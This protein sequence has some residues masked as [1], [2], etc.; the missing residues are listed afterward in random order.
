[1]NFTFSHEQ[2]ELQATIR[3]FCE[4]KSPSAEV[5]RLMETPEGYDEAV[6]KQMAQELGLQGIAIPEEYGGQ[7]FS[8]IEL[9][10]VMEE[11]GRSLLCAPFFSTVCLGAQSIL[12]AGTD[13]QRGRMLPAIANGERLVALAHAEP[14]GRWDA[15]GIATT[16]TPDGDHFRLNGTKS[17]VVDG[18]IAHTLIVAARVGGEQIGLFVVEADA[19]GV[20]REALPTMDMTRKQSRVTFQDVHGVRLGDAGVGA[21]DKTLHQAAVCLSAE[22]TGG[23]QRALDM[24]VDYAK[25]RVQFGR[26]IGQFQAIKHKCA[27]MLLAVES[28]RT[29][30]YHAMWV[31][32]ADDDELPVAASMA[33]AFCTEA[34][35]KVASDNIQ[36][37]GGIGFT[38]EHD[39]HLY[40]KRAKTSELL[41]GDPVYHRERIADILGI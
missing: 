23:A 11:L 15:A 24:A 17:Y 38:W 13:E 28:A 18:S 39:A 1:V 12:N 4:Q 40:Y 29:A 37:H 27:D 7:G 25:V 36:V 31:A 6:W 5:R 14:N 26:P 9:G 19:D 10:I 30:A 33:K 22:S 32:A 2:D 21:L 3:R 16:A 35:F 20:A 41:L 8:F 34:Y